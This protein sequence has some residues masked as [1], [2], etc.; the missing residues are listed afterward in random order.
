[1]HETDIVKYFWKEAVNTACY[2]Q[3]RIYINQFWIKHHMNYSK[4]E[5]CVSI[6]FISLDVFVIL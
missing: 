1:M 4:E 6:T 5:D 2:V 3:N